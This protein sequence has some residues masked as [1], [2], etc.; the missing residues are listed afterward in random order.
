VP[1]TPP[2]AP[3]ALPQ[4][5]HLIPFVL[6]HPDQFLADY[7]GPPALDSEEYAASV[8]ES[9]NLGSAGSARSADQTQV[10]LF[11]ADNAGLHWNRIAKTVAL[12]QP[13]DLTTTARLFAQ[14]NIA[15]ADA[16]ITV[17]TSKYKYDAWRPYHAI[18]ESTPY[19]PGITP[20][21]SFVSLVA[22]PNH[23]EYGSGHSTAC[24]AAAVVLARHFGDHVTFVHTTDTVSPLL[25][26]T[27]RT[28]TGF[29]AASREVDDARVFGGIHFRFTVE[30]S[31]AVGHRVGEYIVRHAMRAED[32]GD[33]SR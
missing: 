15:L 7:A 25:T 24:A 26:S 29:S 8:N 22:T 23:Q 12:A 1:P 20:D 31:H 21:P 2:G 27:T 33:E 19:N 30:A 13:E 10:A 18:R 16:A 6:Q 32:E 28:I 5:V 3:A 9:K 4:F 17:W 14:L 11:W